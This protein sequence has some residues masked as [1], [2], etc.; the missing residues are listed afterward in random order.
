[1]AKK[2]V[3]GRNEML[4][5]NIEIASFAASVVLHAVHRRGEDPYIESQPWL[6][7]RGTATE[8]VGDVRDSKSVC[9]REKT[10]TMWARPDRRRLGPSFRFG[11]S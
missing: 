9:F 3:S 4:V 1:M 7:L 6:E 10:R 2:H 5:R 8:P 11:R